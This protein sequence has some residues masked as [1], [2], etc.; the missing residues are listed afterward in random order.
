MERMIALYCNQTFSLHKPS[1][2]ELQRVLCRVKEMNTKLISL[3]TAAEISRTL[4]PMDPLKS[5]G[6]D[7]ISPIVFFNSISI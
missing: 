6:S 5:P 7:D 1:D 2:Y 4:S 3:F